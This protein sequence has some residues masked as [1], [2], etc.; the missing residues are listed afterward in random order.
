MKDCRMDLRK[1]FLRDLRLEI[2]PLPVL[3]AGCAEEVKA[4]ECHG[5]DRVGF[6]PERVV[7]KWMRQWFGKFDFDLIGD[8]PRRPGLTER[9]NRHQPI[10][11]RQSW[12]YSNHRPPL[13]HFWYAKSSAVVTQKNSA[14]GHGEPD[15]HIPLIIDNPTRLKKHQS[16]MIVICWRSVFQGAPR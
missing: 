6:H 5:S 4:I 16:P 13:D 3:I 12:R 2:F 15:R 1:L 14:R 8:T 11:M 10:A 7:G 9:H